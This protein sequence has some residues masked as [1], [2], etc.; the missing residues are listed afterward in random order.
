MASRHC[1]IDSSVFV[2]F[3]R[4]VDTLHRDALR[5]MQ[6]LSADVLIVHPYVIQE[7]ATVLTYGAGLT[8]A[9]KFL[10]DVA[11]ASNIIIPPVNIQRDIQLFSYSRAKLSFTDIALIGLA[12]EMGVPLITFDRQML[13]LSKKF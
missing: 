11:T 7:T 9:K 12:K 8:V 5:V 3:Y 1:V 6:E 4:D 13:A 2:A 10:S